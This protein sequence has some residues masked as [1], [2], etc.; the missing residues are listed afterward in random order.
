MNICSFCGGKNRE[1]LFFCDNCGNPLG[2]SL[3]QPTLPTRRLDDTLDEYTARATWGSASVGGAS[4][5]VFHIRDASEPFTVEIKDRVLIGRSD[6]TSPRQPDLDLTPFGALEKGV[7]RVH[8]VIERNE[9][10]LTLI[11]MDSSNGTFLNGQR[12]ISDNP[13]VLR[14]GDEVRFGKLIGHIYFK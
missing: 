7:S 11:D 12:L 10:V 5:V 13:R 4:S 2:D 3:P 1:G 9:D 6:N 14:D 8:A